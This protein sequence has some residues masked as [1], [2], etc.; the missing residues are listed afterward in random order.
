MLTVA[1]HYVVNMDTVPRKKAFDVVDF[2]IAKIRAER[3]AADG[4]ARPVT[5]RESIQVRIQPRKS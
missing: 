5:R 3:A 4:G 1:D 2:L